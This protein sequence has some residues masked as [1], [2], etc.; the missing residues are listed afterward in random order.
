MA[1]I[2]T[3]KK[4]SGIKLGSLVKDTVTG[5]TGIAVG[6]TEFAFGC[7]HI[8]VQ[9]RKLS[10]DGAP[11]PVQSFDDQRIE[12]LAPPTKSWAEPRKIAVKLGNVAR[13]TLTGTVGTVTSKTVGVEGQVY[14]VIEP[15]GLTENGETNP[16]LVVSA[17]WIEVVDK[18]ELAVSKSSAATSGGPAARGVSLP[19]NI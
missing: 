11:I 7:I 9:A 17:G 15:P 10:T 5:F 2:T 14:F 3:K 19:P 6:R 1:N 13:D 8:R 18:R 16:P 4:A 12:L